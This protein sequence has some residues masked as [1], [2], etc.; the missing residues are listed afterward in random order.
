MITLQINM[1]YL[2]NSRR[3]LSLILPIK[4]LSIFMMAL[5]ICAILPSHARTLKVSSTTTIV[6]TSTIAATQYEL[7]LVQVLSEICPPML[8]PRQQ[9]QFYQA[10]QNQLRLFM[11]TATDPNDLLNQ[12]GT[13]RHYQYILQNM[14]AWTATFPEQE[15]KALCQDFAKQSTSLSARHQ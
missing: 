6:D 10:Y 12:I 14:R 3:L 9:T 11:P 7:A 15:N 5:G 2:T 13:Q 8:T 4:H 1:D